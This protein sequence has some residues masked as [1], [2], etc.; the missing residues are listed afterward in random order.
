MATL[1]FPH[2]PFVAFDGDE[3][4]AVEHERHA[5][6]AWGPRPASGTAATHQDRVLVIGALLFSDL[7]GRDLARDAL[8]AK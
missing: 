3:P 8:T 6:A 2:R 4:A 5:D 7:V 1:R